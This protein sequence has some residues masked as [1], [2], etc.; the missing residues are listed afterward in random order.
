MPHEKSE[1]VKRGSRWYNVDTVG[2]D[3]GRILGSPGGF[4]TQK[5]ASA[6]AEAR[7][8]RFGTVKSPRR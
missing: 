1:T 4:T 6:A 5:K 8:R 7:S 2:K 3:K